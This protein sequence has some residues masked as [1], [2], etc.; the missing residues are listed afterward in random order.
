[1]KR[2]RLMDREHTHANLWMEKDKRTFWSHRR[3]AQYD[4]DDLSPDGGGDVV[5]NWFQIEG[6]PEVCIIDYLTTRPS[7]V[8]GKG[9]A[10][11]TLL[12]E[13]GEMLDAGC[14]Y[15]GGNILNSTEAR[16]F[17]GRFDVKPKRFGYDAFY[18]ME[19]MQ[20]AEVSLK[21]VEV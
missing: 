1:M 13:V 9:Y 2:C 10:T 3:S 16:G 20:P 18:D 7:W 15:L 12:Y 8:R 11:E 19:T 4:C 6:K 17:W 14:R 21:G 5:I